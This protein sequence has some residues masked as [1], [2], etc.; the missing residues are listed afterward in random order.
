MW[1]NSRQW[2][3]HCQRS[4]ETNCCFQFHRNALSAL[5]TAVGRGGP[6]VQALN[7]APARALRSLYQVAPP[8]TGIWE[9]PRAWP[10]TELP[11]L[12]L[13]KI[14]ESVSSPNSPLTP[15]P[16]LTFFYIEGGL[17]KPQQ[18][19]P[20]AH[21]PIITTPPT[22]CFKNSRQIIYWTLLLFYTMFFFI[23][24]FITWS[25]TWCPSVLRQNVTP[26]MLQ[27]PRK[28]KFKVLQMSSHNCN[29]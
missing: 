6:R 19:S 17:V 18:K 14:I 15:D 21:A 26:P 3:W 25:P 12:L 10:S 24:I 28:R 27:R 5:H 23:L 20:P 8:Q 2:Q 4:I 9:L 1:H 13:V 7:L 22:H 29:G 16:P 11:G